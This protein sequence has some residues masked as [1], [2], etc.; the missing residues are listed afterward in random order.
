MGPPG[1]IG[2]KEADGCLTGP[3]SVA[4]RRGQF[5]VLLVAALI[6][7]GCIV[8]P[9]ALMDDMDATQAQIARTMLDSG[10]WVTARI[11]GVIYLEKPPLKYWLIAISFRVFGVRDWAARIP[12]AL[13]AVLLC[14]VTALFGTWA[15]DARAGTYAG[16][17]L[18]TCIGLF[19]FT[20]VLIPDVMLTLAITVALWSLVRAL[21]EA[22][23]RPGRWAMLM[24]AALGT[25]LLLKGLI[26]IVF[27]VTA[28]ALYL[29]ITRQLFLRKT[30][31]R[32]HPLTGMA[33]LLAVALPWHALAT[34]RNPPYFDFTMH[35]ERG[36]YHGFFWFYFIN[37]HLLRY[38]GRRYPRDYNT[39]PRLYFWLFHLIWL[40]PW[41]VYLPAVAKLDFKPADRAGRTR[42]LALCWIGFILL[43]FSF[44][45]T[46]EYYSMPCYPALALLI[47]C[48][49]ASDGRLLAYGTRA[50]AIIA[51]LCC[52]VI[53]IILWLVRALPAPGDISVAL[54]Q[55]P[56]IYTA[57]TLSLGH[58]GDLT[59]RAFAYLRLPLALAGLG[60]LIGAAGTWKSSGRR[61][62][63]AIVL[64]M[65]LFFHAARLA[66][67]TFDPYLGSR[68]LAEAL[69]RSPEGRLIVDDQYYAF[70]SVMFYANRRALLL[71]GRINNIEYGSYAP[72]AP[73]VFL[74]DQQFARLWSEPERYYLVAAG[75]AL[76]RFEKLVGKPALHVVVES[77]G[78]FLF[79][80]R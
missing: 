60:L 56:D 8:S 12:T 38:L 23:S 73:D 4:G 17:C 33:L 76:A 54:N 16:L 58:M 13:S 18:A 66:L 79:T 62:V 74:D 43:F 32:I 27:P 9:P 35:S 80:N 14:W 6:F 11:N 25:G 19:L 31:T 48:A 7:L 70:S 15:F 53:A 45:T 64:M 47:G 71:N 52:A 29:A 20:R 49:L 24:W 37:E 28:S 51:T 30:W 26:A 36:S 10:D 34:I 68:P 46:Q 75:P 40:F 21:N 5:V 42:L 55:N 61:A 44:S 22:E 72:G 50:A 67:V 65:V 41:S 78:K 39:V 63:P 2:L 59:L 69:N 3:G 77:G 57:Y 1:A